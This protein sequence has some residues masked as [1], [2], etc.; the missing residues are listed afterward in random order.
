MLP[1]AHRLLVPLTLLAGLVSVSRTVAA[2]QHPPDETV[3]FVSTANDFIRKVNFFNNTTTVINSTENPVNIEWKGIAIRDDGGT[4]GIKV[5]VSDNQGGRLFM[6]AGADVSTTVFGDEVSNSMIRSQ[7][8]KPAALTLDRDGILFIL[9]SASGSSA[10][11]KRK[12]WMLERGNVTSGG[13]AGSATLIDDNLPNNTAELQDVKVANFKSSGPL[14]KDGDVFVLAKGPNRVLRYRKSN[15]CPSGETTVQAGYCRAI[16][17][18]GLGGSSGVTFSTT[19]DLLISRDS[20]SVLRYNMNGATPTLVS[21]NFAS[22]QGTGTVRIAV[23]VQGGSDRAFTVDKNG[24]RVRRNTIVNGGP[25]DGTGAAAGTVSQ[26]VND[27]V[28]LALASASAVPTQTGANVFVQPC[29]TLSS[30][31]DVVLQRGL[32]NARCM[33]FADLRTDLYVTEEIPEGFTPSTLVA[34]SWPSNCPN[35]HSNP[36]CPKTS[37]PRSSLD[38]DEFCLCEVDKQ[39]PAILVPSN[40][41]AHRQG[42]PVSGTPTFILVV[43]DTTA[44]WEGAATLTNLESFVLGYEPDCMLDGALFE[45]EPRLFTAPETATSG[46]SKDETPIREGDDGDPDIFADISTSC[47]SH[48]KG[49]SWCFSTFL[50]GRD[51]LE[52]FDI[53]TSKFD[54]LDEAINDLNGGNAFG[55]CSVTSGTLNCRDQLRKDLCEAW[56]NSELSS[57]CP[58]YCSGLGV[59]CTVPICSEPDATAAMTSFLDVIALSP[60]TNASLSVDSEFGEREARNEL[61]SRA[62]SLKYFIKKFSSSQL[63]QCVP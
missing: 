48:N 55:S 13:Y 23:G 49:Q 36:R 31:F 5:F 28:A 19:G 7:I 58:S 37:M 27:P 8:Q 17:I 29:S 3:Y 14:V 61:K 22:G 26:G 4:G 41:L 33:A 11:R 53:V 9:N 42:N 18:S 38:P 40:V 12:L 21:P 35:A 47:A 45:E 32:T 24:D 6:Y 10:A 51:T 56:G 2:Q 52:P 59:T 43:M 60:D 1:R 34:P 16:L 44:T 30:E 50:Y 46:S 25:A 63:G 20:G 62:E 15:S 39:L 54:F 57:G